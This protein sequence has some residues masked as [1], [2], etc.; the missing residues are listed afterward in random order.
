MTA[1]LA[2]LHVHTTRSDGYFS[3][4]EIVDKA[5]A[6]GLKAIAISDHDEISGI[7]EAFT[8]GHTRG[9]EVIAAVELSVSYRNHDLHVLGY[10][11]DYT[12]AELLNYIDLFKAER[13]RRAETIVRKLAGMGMP[14]SFEAVLEKAGQGSIGRPHIANVLIEQKY[15][16]SF[17]EA[18]NRYLG[19]GKP[20]Y[21]DKYRFELEHAFDLIRKVGGVCA[22][23][24]PG[25]QLTNG[26][27]NAL[28]QQGVEA[29][30][31]VHPK[32]DREQTLKYRELAEKHGLIQT[33][34]SDFHGGSKGEESFGKYTVPME[35][36][37]QIKSVTWSRG[38]L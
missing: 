24:H 4:R 1:R 16:Y 27:L 6:V 12:R 2:D 3:P 35:I 14:I 8:Y 21:V 25:I 11:F 38:T 17:E 20:A 30:E 36:V 22:I 32:H 34:G 37:A 29:L 28:I 33:G 19:T 5:L 7:D 18:F 31:V 15:V 13:V 9:L 26:D 23:A 10:G